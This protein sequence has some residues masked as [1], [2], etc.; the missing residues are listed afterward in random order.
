MIRKNKGNTLIQNE[1][2]HSNTP[3]P[4]ITKYLYHTSCH[5]VLLSYCVSPPA[6]PSISPPSKGTMGSG[7]GGAMSAP[8]A[9]S[10]WARRSAAA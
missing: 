1:M 3:R 10:S 4:S 5:M 6:A 2:K 8:P 7:A 9:A